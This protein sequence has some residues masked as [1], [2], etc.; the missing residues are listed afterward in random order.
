MS[1]CHIV[2][3]LMSHLTYL[4]FKFDKQHN[5]MLGMLGQPQ[6]L[7]SDQSL[8]DV[9]DMGTEYFPKASFIIVFRL[10]NSLDKLGSI[11]CKLIKFV[12]DY[13]RI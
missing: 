4:R 6:S 3:N 2:G 10:V 11:R 9:L 1:K 8:C 7:K 5:G 12:F 13:S